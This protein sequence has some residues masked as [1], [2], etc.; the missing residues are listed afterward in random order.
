MR[1]YLK[2]KARQAKNLLAK[3]KREAIKL[4]VAVLIGEIVLVTG[5]ALAVKYSFTNI[6][7][8]SNTIEFVQAK[9]IEKP[10]AS[11]PK[12]RVQELAEYIWNKESTQG[13]HNYSQ[14]EAQGKVNGIGYGIPGNGNYICFESHDE[15]MTA[16]KGWIT[17]KFAQGYS[18]KELLCTYQSGKRKSTCAYANAI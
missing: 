13:L 6:F 9:T 14:C 16:L 8:Q 5:Y 18:E 2:I 7:Y 15:E 4:A 10:K 17:T 12:D 3:A 1:V 11:E